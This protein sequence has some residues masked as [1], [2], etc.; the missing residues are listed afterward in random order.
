MVS[1]ERGAPLLSHPRNSWLCQCCRWVAPTSLS[2]TPQVL[3]VGGGAVTPLQQLE[4]LFARKHIR[5]CILPESKLPESILDV[6]PFPG[7]HTLSFRA[8]RVVSLTHHFLSLALSLSLSLS[9]PPLSLSL[10]Y[11]YIYIYMYIYINI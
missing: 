10:I 5:R 8:A 2:N 7:T 3:Q 1:Y 11:I 6:Q 4:M 9:P